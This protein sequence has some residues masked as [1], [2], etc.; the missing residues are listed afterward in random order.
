MVSIPRSVLRARSVRKEDVRTFAEPPS[1]RL[2]KA[3]DRA[4]EGV[5]IALDPEER[6]ALTARIEVAPFFLLK[7]VWTCVN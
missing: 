4:E 5:Y 6:C 2:K 1:P 7:R 3:A